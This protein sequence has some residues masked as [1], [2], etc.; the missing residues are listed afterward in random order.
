MQRFFLIGYMGAGK[1]T[2]GKKM[3]QQLNL[4][5]I[6]LDHFIEKRYHRTI[7]QIFAEKGESNF[8]EIEARTL[9]EVA[10]FENIVLSTGGGTPCFHNNL[11][12]MNDTGITIYLKV[13]PEELARRLEICK[14]SRPLIKDKTQD[15]LKTFIAE[16]LLK[17]EMFYNRTSIILEAEKMMTRT[18]IQHT[19]NQLIEQINIFTG[20]GKQ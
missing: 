19:V 6:D 15:E 5:F 11:Q 16:N 8:R 17:R 13:S 14:N 20:N 10:D 1:T 18:D 12:R 7:S 2:I 9:D 3:A 4:D